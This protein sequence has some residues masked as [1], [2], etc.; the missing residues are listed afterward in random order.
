MTLTAGV[1]KNSLVLFVARL[2]PVG[3]VVV[4]LGKALIGGAG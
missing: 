1:D 2:V 4:R 3:H